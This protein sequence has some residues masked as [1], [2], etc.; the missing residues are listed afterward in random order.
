MTIVPL[1]FLSA[2]FMASSPLFYGAEAQLG[3]GFLLASSERKF[4]SQSVTVSRPPTTTAVQP[5]AQISKGAGSAVQSRIDAPVSRVDTFPSVPT[6]PS[7][8]LSQR[9]KI[10]PPVAQSDSPPGNGGAAGTSARNPGMSSP[11]SQAAGFSPATNAPSAAAGS[12]VL[13]VFAGREILANLHPADRSIASHSARNA[14]E[15]LEDN[16]IVGWA[17]PITGGNG[18]ITPLRTFKLAGFTACRDYQM[19]LTMAG[20]SETASGS[21]CRG[22][23]GAWQMVR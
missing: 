5:K 8:V 19:T 10:Q 12:S 17:S 20:R 1:D 16:A 23:D 3:E 21:A 11:T 13:D 4:T 6:G 22:T 7:Q 15:N 14:L 18:S 2:V 9:A